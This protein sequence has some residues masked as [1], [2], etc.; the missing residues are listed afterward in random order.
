[1]AVSSIQIVNAAGAALTGPVSINLPSPG[2]TVSDTSIVIDTSAQQFA[3]VVNANSLGITA[4]A[5]TADRRFS[6]L[7]ARTTAISSATPTEMFIVGIPPTYD[8][9]TK[10]AGTLAFL[11]PF[12]DFERDVVGTITFPGTGLRQMTSFE[13][14][15]VAGNTIAGVPVINQT[16]S[17]TS[18]AGGT[19]VTLN[20]AATTGVPEYSGG[21][22]LLDDV[23]KDGNNDGNDQHH[24]AHNFEEFFR[25]QGKDSAPES[26]D[27]VMGFNRSLCW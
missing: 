15:D 3:N 19:L 22:N 10:L 21:F 14:V 2:V 6:V 5:P 8:S 4:G 13:I 18:N 27:A 17:A 12:T 26:C 16:G 1:M 23:T 24:H 9:T 25:R 11:T 20:I 7:S